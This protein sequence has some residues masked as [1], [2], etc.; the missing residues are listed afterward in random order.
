MIPQ[1][2]EFKKLELADK[3]EIESFTKKFPPYSDFNFVSMWSWDTRGGMSISTLNNNL[4]VKF[5]DY[6]SKEPFYS[7]IGDSEIDS[8]ID[9]LADFSMKKGLGSKLKLIPNDM[10][11][12]SMNNNFI[13]I[14]DQD[15]FDYIYKVKDFYDCEGQ[16]YE[17]QR[18]QINRFKKKYTNIKVEVYKNFDPIREN[19]LK[20][21]FEWKAAKIQQD[22][23]LEFINESEAMSRILKLDLSNFVTICIFSEGKLIAFCINELIPNSPYALAHFAKADV[24][25]SGVYSFLLHETCKVLIEEGKEFLNYEQ[26]LGIEY[27]RQSKNSFR[28]IDFLKKHSVVKQ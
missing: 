7:F 17:T 26:D 20:L 24:S 27:L 6:L 4:V 21:E 19:I 2:P 9:V 11:S 22:R 25:F 28:P 1:F 18:N 3:N 12:L 14:P 13:A 15:N 10:L 16:K 5:N 23:I 8:T